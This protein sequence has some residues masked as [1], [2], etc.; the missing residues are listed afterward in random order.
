GKHKK[1]IR[2]EKVFTQFKWKLVHSVPQSYLTAE[3]RKTLLNSILVLSL[4]IIIFLVMS[5]IMAKK[6]HHPIKGL[7]KV[8]TEF[9]AGNR[10]VRFKDTSYS[11][12][13]DLGQSINK[14]FNQIN[15]L[16]VNI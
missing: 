16:I 3:L 4:F 11:E 9:G 5:L 1:E 2:T 6:L 12:I 15:D 7:Q 14:M 10:D 13:N 8:A